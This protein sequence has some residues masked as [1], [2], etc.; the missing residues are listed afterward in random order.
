MGQPCSVCG[1]GP[2]ALVG[3]HACLET[4]LC[5]HSGPQDLSRAWS[6]CHPQPRQCAFR[7]HVTFCNASCL[8]FGLSIS[9]LRSRLRSH[10]HSSRCC[11]FSFL[12]LVM[13][14]CEAQCPTPRSCP[15][16]FSSK[17]SVTK[18]AGRSSLELRRSSFCEKQRGSVAMHPSHGNGMDQHGG[19]A[20]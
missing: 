17:C 14:S 5:R 16:G 8:N 15:S 20:C 10:L 18:G 4:L 2:F 13:Y 1:R 6:W 19:S 9:S 12:A 3:S 7:G 11:I